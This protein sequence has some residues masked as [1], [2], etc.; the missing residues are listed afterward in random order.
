MPLPWLQ[1]K[2]PNIDWI[3]VFPDIKS[4]VPILVKHPDYFTNLDRV[5]SESKKDT[6]KVYQ[7]FTILMQGMWQYLPYDK[8]FDLYAFTDTPMMQYDWMEC[9][10]FTFDLLNSEL[11]QEYAVKKSVEIATG[12]ESI[13]SVLSNLSTIARMNINNSTDLSANTKVSLDNILTSL[14]VVGIKEPPLNRSFELLPFTSFLMSA[15]KCLQKKFTEDMSRVGA[16]VS[17]LESTWAE[18]TPRYNRRIN[19]I[20]L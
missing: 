19:S 6:V 17:F 12:L 5:I 20:G 9:V 16:S 11:H 1:F 14:S 15:S 4:E 3:A 10:N 18:M 8:R 7:L 2:Y 13:A